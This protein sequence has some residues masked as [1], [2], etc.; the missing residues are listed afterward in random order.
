MEALRRGE[1]STLLE[2]LPTKARRLGGEVEEALVS[3]LLEILPNA[4][5]RCG[6]YCY[7]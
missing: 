1:V 6:Y 4:H 7:S 3:T 5:Q 2:I